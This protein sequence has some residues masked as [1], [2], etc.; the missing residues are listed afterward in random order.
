MVETGELELGRVFTAR[1]CERFPVEPFAIRQLE[2]KA[3]GVAT[4]AKCSLHMTA[5]RLRKMPYVV[6]RVSD[7]PFNPPRDFRAWWN[8]PSLDDEAVGDPSLAWAFVVCD[9]GHPIWNH[10]EAMKLSYELDRAQIAATRNQRVRDADGYYTDDDVQRIFKTQDGR[11]AYCRDV[12]S[13]AL[14]PTVDHIV[15]LAA[16]GM[17]WPSNL[18]LACQ[19]CNSKKGAMSQAAFLE[20][21]A[22]ESRS[23]VQR[24]IAS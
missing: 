23:G 8:S 15:P 6:D 5:F 10:P 21:I 2:R 14:K 19:T 24:R 11:C 13:E 20:Q 3:F 7:Y 12:F 1:T 17:H 9:C 18:C 4:C 16:G 22:V